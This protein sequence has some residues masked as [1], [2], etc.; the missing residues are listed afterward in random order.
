MKRYALWMLGSEQRRENFRGSADSSNLLVSLSRR[1][2]PTSC[3]GTYAIG[4]VA[5]STILALCVVG[6]S[7]T[8]IA[9]RHTH[10]QTT[11]TP[12]V[13]LT[14]DFCMHLVAVHT[15]HTSK[16]S[17]EATM[18]RG[19]QTNRRN[20]KASATRVVSALVAVISSSLLLLLLLL[21]LQC[22]VEAFAP[23]HQPQQTPRHVVAPVQRGDSSLTLIPFP[24][25]QR[26]AFHSQRRRSYFN[27]NAMLE[28]TSSTTTMSLSR[29]KQQLRSFW[30]GRFG[31]R[32]QPL[33]ALQERSSGGGTATSPT[34]SNSGYDPLNNRHSA[35]DWLYNV[36]SLPQSK[37]LREIRNPVLAV[38][39]WSASVSILHAL[40]KQAG[41]TRWA[42]HLCIPG[43]A[44]SFLVSALGLLLVFR[45]NSA[46]QRFN[47]R[48][49]CV[50]C[51]CV[52]WMLLSLEECERN[53]HLLFLNLF[54]C[55]YILGGTQDLGEYSECQS[56]HESHDS[57][58]RARSGTRKP[59]A[60]YQLGGGLS[61]LVAPTHSSRLSVQ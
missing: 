11:H 36:R 9:A 41:W 43:T 3:V 33:K 34:G 50:E 2:Y 20:C 1:I 58:V 39:A 61:L 25:A 13:G 31:A 56:Q 16:I 53:R 30:S 18:M 60:H 17:S 23:T 47:V 5:G 29:A 49:N 4:L 27:T 51:V 48:T 40:L 38:A 28:P 8:T 32:T 22:R 44:H 42:A 35:S 6:Q 57:I 7:S 12:A 21:L 59:Q 10:A 52:C 46:Y 37:V 26:H 15:S 14:R 45:T 24:N 55:I 19:T 54:F